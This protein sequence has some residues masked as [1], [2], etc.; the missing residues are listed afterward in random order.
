MA[1]QALR[2]DVVQAGLSALYAKVAGDSSTAYYSLGDFYEG[3]F[4]A[5]MLA[6]KNKKGIANGHSMELVTTA[7]LMYTKKT[8]MMSVL[9]VLHKRD[10]DI[11]VRTDNGIDISSELLTV[12]YFGFGWKFVCEG[13][14]DKDRYIEIMSD[15]LITGAEWT[16][17]RGTMPSLGVADPQDELYAIRAMTAAE[18]IAAGLSKVEFRLASA[19]SWTDELGSIRNAKVEVEGLTTKQQHGRTIG[20]KNIRVKVSVEALQSSATELALLAASSST[21]IN[22]LYDFKI[23]FAGDGM[24]MTL[25][26]MAGA[27]FSYANDKDA[28]DVSIIKLDIEGTITETQLASLFT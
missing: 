15:R 28:D 5:N 13:D 18:V 6:R 22:A 19:G 21:F 1:W 20:Q 3:K 8:V 23:T 16:T 25:D 7:R 12:P 24:I 2:G 11:I 14:M 4:S 17:V 10:L 27:V 9:P 26:N